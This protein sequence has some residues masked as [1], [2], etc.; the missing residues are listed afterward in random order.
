MAD[1]GWVFP[2]TAASDRNLFANEWGTP[3][4]IKATDANNATCVGSK[5]DLPSP[6]NPA[7]EDGA[8]LIATNF[9]LSV[10][11]GATITGVE[12]RIKGRSDPNLVGELAYLT[13]GVSPRLYGTA[14]VDTWT[15]L[16]TS[17]PQ[18]TH[19]YGTPTDLWGATLTPTIVNGTDFGW[20]FMTYDET[21]PLNMLVD[22]MQIKVYYEEA[23][24]PPIIMMIGA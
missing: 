18:G 20:I 1:T 24:I 23:N 12:A 4:N 11:A 21:A 6:G 14:K 16:P 8:E 3:D 19:I 17:D 13:N 15:D 9:G 22:Y 7:A 2:G 10:P 5:F